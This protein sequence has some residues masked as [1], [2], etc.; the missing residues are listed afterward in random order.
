MINTMRPNHSLRVEKMVSVLPATTAMLQILVAALCLVAP[1]VGAATRTASV[2]GYW[3]NTATWGGP[4]PI[5]GDTAVINNGVTV[6]LDQSPAELNSLTNNGTLMFTG[7]PD[8]ILTATVVQVNGTITHAA[9]SAIATNA[10]GE[11]VEDAGIQIVCSNLTISSS[12][13]ISADEKGFGGGPVANP[14]DGYGPGHG[15]RIASRNVGGGGYGGVGGPV[16]GAASGISYGN[17]ASPTNAGSGGCGGNG[18][19]GAG[20]GIVQIDAT[21]GRVT[22][23][24]KITADGGQG[25][26]GNAGDPGG[27]GSGGAVYIRCKSITGSGCI[28]ADGGDSGAQIVSQSVYENGGGGGGRVAIDFNTTSQAA[29]SPALMISAAEGQGRSA[30]SAYPSAT[31]SYFGYP[32]TVDMTGTNLL[33]GNTGGGRILIPGWTAWTYGFLTISNG[34][35]VYPDGMNLTVQGNV[36]LIGRGALELSNGTIQIDGDLT[37]SSTDVLDAGKF[38]STIYGGF[39]ESTVVDGRLNMSRG[40]LRFDGVD[41]NGA[42]LKVGGSMLMTNSSA[43]IMSAAPASA[44]PDTGVTLSIGNDMTVALDSW[45][46]VISNPTNGSSV[47]FRMRDL[48]VST[49]S[50]FSAST[51]GYAGATLASPFDRGWGPGAGTNGTGTSGAGAGY[52]GVGGSNTVV[53]GGSTY[54]DEEAPM[55]LGSGG[56]GGSNGGRPG[57]A[58]GG[59]IR[60]DARG[61]IDMDG[62]MAANGVA[63][64]SSAGVGSGG[65]SGGGIYLLCSTFEGG[66]RMEAEGGNGGKQDPVLY[67]AGGGGGGGRIAVWA[68]EQLYAGTTSVSGGTVRVNQ[69]GFPGTVFFG[70]RPAVGCVITIR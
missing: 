67:K 49:D 58:G 47:L 27:G 5:A 17:S 6:T 32:G 24:G 53:G 44:V 26:T 29:E 68:Y 40:V 35:A 48:S 8:T 34:T 60:I 38:Q 42:V 36:A 1:C 14:R 31:V 50:G 4:V 28:S 66:G 30:Y 52:G 55:F 56:G 70:V 16:G 33:S 59:L 12:G 25:G 61:T 45:V 51:Y 64:T 69:D 63:G 65:G 18:L 11:W 3:T 22:V 37:I 21:L 43:L 41:T 54:G 7:W 9:Q 23:D 20:G 15:I 46:T 10:Q 2:S 57:G 62:V 39:G 13:Q 19:G